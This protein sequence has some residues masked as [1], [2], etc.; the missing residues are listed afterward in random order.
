MN[1]R[2][3]IE[4]LVFFA[5]WFLVGGGV[6][7]WTMELFIMASMGG[8]FE[9]PAIWT[10]ARDFG[11]VALPFL[12]FGGAPAAIKIMRGRPWKIAAVV[13]FAICATIWVALMLVVI[14]G[15]PVWGWSW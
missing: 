3:K 13:A 1:I 5:L 10:F 9:P 11:F 4:G 6:I 2:N 15:P 7:A 8:V 12:P 14:W